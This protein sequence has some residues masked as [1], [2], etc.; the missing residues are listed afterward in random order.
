MLNSTEKYLQLVYTY[1]FYIL[2]TDTLHALIPCLAIILSFQHNGNT[3]TVGTVVIF[4]LL[5]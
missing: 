1:V 5:I 3:S 4:Q 2:N